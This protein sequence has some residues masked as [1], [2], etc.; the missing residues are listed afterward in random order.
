MYKI[1]DGEGVKELDIPLSA[2]ALAI[3]LTVASADIYN[4]E[5]TVVATKETTHLNGRKLGG[6]AG[7]QI[8][9][10]CLFDRNGE[11]NDAYFNG[12]QILQ[13]AK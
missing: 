11:A 3:T 5:I 12:F 8:S 9:S 10:F 1:Y 7:A 6:T 4:L 2:G 13:P